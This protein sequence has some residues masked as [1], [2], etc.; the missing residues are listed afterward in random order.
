MREEMRSYYAKSNG[1]KRDQM[2]VCLQ[3]NGGMH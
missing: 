1:G 2:V 3:L